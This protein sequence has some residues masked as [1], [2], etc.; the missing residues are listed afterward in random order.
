[1][2]LIKW[3]LPLIP[4]LIFNVWV[5]WLE[6]QNL[7]PDPIA[8]HWGLMGEPNGFAALDS[9]L[10]WSNFALLI[11]AA[12]LS[13][14]L[15]YP[16]IYPSLRKLFGIIVGYFYLFIT[17]LMFYVTGIQIGSSNAAQTSLQAWFLPIVLLP[18]VILIPLTLS[19]PTV[20]LGSGLEVRIWNIRFLKLDFDQISSVSKEFIKPSSFGGW[21]IR[22]SGGKVAF[23]SSKGPALRIDTKNGE[24]ILIRSNQVEN[25]IAAI[26]P[27]LED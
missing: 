6:S 5:F 17:A 1:M 11:A 12:I 10:L 14:V 9:Y 18:V 25:L 2:K 23:V 4:A 20:V 27:K 16:K 19:K 15:W 24:V 22:I 8:T 13:L 3:L 21:G 7:L 26:K